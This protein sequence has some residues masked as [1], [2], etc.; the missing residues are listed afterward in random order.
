MVLTETD[1]ERIGSEIQTKEDQLVFLEDLHAASERLYER[2]ASTEGLRGEVSDKFL[3]V[4]QGLERDKL[5]PLEPAGQE[6]F[7]KKLRDYVEKL[8]IVR[9]TLA[10]SP[11][12]ELVGKIRS[13]FSAEGGGLPPILDVYVRD[14]IGGGIILEHAGVYRD[15]SLSKGLDNLVHDKE[16]LAGLLA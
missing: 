11:R 4:V 10:F 15:L 9:V 6:A 7:F 12:R 14:E 13:Y 16:F 8:P 2:G 3:K 5:L 1:L